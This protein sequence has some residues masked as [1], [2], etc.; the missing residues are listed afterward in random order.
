MSVENFFFTHQVDQIFFILTWDKNN[1]NIFFYKRFTSKFKQIEFFVYLVND[2]FVNNY[3]ILI[4]IFS[5]KDIILKCYTLY[6]LT[7]L[8]LTEKSK[9]KG[10]YEVATHY[11]NFLANFGY[12]W[13]CNPITDHDRPVKVIYCLDPIMHQV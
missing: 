10:K 13:T 4:N 8:F 12:V 6:T 9:K 1:L 2:Y 7:F 11:N 3:H 5:E